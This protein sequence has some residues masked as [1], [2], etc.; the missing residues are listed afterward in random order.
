VFEGDFYYP[1][2]AK[3]HFDSNLMVRTGS[4]RGVPLYADTTLEPF[5]VV[6][7]PV[8][9]AM[10]QPYERRSF[11]QVLGRIGRTHGGVTPAATDVGQAAAPPMHAPS[12]A[13][14]IDDLPPPPPAGTAPPPLRLEPKP[15]RPAAP[16]QPGARN[17]VWIEFKGQRWKSA[18][19]AVGY[20]EDRFVPF[21]RYD[22]VDVYVERRPRQSRNPRRIYVTSRP[23]VVAPFER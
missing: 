23:G 11:G 10:M 8:G 20:A 1:I 21:G 9:G 18:G 2:G 4:Y 13:P 17:G 15:S 3:R 12:I 6:F 7:V 22:G 16:A 19:Q 14:L 5:T